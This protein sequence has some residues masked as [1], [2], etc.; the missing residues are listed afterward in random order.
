MN[1]VY[2]ALLDYLKEVAYSK[3]FDEFEN[4]FKKAK[5]LK[6]LNCLLKIPKITKFIELYE[7]IEDF[8]DIF[9]PYI[10]SN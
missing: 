2:S 1:I 8:S 9:K 10:V 5:F 7:L 3:Q 6:V 4:A